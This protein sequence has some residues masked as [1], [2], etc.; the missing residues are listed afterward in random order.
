[1]FLAAV[2]LAAQEADV[3]P[4]LTKDLAGIVATPQEGMMLTVDMSRALRPTS[5]V[6]NAHT[7]VYVLEGSVVMQV[8]EGK[9]VTLGPGQTLY[10]SPTDIHTVSRNASGTEQKARDCANKVNCWTIRSMGTQNAFCRPGSRRRHRNGAVT[11][12]RLQ[13]LPVSPAWPALCPKL[14]A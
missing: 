12:T 11:P 4:L 8:K 2:T 14:R 6:T 7:F 1:V 10:E 5:T 9:E 3:A 13:S